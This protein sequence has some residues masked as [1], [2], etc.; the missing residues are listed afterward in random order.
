MTY[1]PIYPIPE[2]G[3][4]IRQL[5][6]QPPATP[7]EMGLVTGK[8]SAESRAV[9]LEFS[10]RYLAHLLR[11]VVEHY[12]VTKVLGHEWG[13]AAAKGFDWIDQ[14]FEPHIRSLAGNKP[15]NAG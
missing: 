6:F 15:G 3:P 5:S 13:P 8:G 1:E 9:E 2:G 12:R 7:V 4:V 11:E 14:E 10:K